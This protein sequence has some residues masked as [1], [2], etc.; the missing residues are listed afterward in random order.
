MELG[1]HDIIKGIVL[2]PKST[3]LF[4]KFGKITFKVDFA[5]NKPMIKEA[6][7]KIWDV[8]VEDIRVVTLPGKKRKFARKVFTSSKQKKAVVSL[9]K[10]YKID[11]PGHQFESTGLAPEVVAAQTEEK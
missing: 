7:E 10:G 2:T 3:D 9:K 1:I 6:V 8:K 4:K 5:A 11:L